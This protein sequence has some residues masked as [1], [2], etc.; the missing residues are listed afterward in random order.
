MHGSSSQ[1]SV[2]GG[3]TSPRQ[4]EH[5]LQST[6]CVPSGHEVV[7]TGSHAGLGPPQH[8]CTQYWPGVHS[9]SPH[10][11]GSPVVAD[12]PCPPVSVAVDSPPP[13]ADALALES[14]DAVALVEAPDVASPADAD[15]VAEPSSPPPSSPQATASNAEASPRHL[16]AWLMV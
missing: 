1:H 6:S 3:H 2:P 4:L 10:T 11:T 15:D 9:S 16:L 14:A 8:G 12:V 5:W 13:E 7:S